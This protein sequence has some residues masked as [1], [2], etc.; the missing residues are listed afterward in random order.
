[1]PRPRSRASP[2]RSPSHVWQDRSEDLV[3]S[4][5]NDT[6]GHIQGRHATGVSPLGLM[7]KHRTSI[8][9][10]HTFQQNACVNASSISLLSGIFLFSFPLFSSP[11]F[12]PLPLQSTPHYLQLSLIKTYHSEHEEL[13]AP[14]RGGAPVARQ[15]ATF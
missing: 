14:D 3:L 12:F 7:D 4:R 6:G 15:T 9:R 11:P 8:G 5:L 1:M 13:G 2:S 10:Q